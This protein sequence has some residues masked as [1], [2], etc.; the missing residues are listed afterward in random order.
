MTRRDTFAALAGLAAPS[1]RPNIL[2]IMADDLGYADLSCYGRRDYRTPQLDRLAA[3]GVRF[4]NAYASSCVCSPTRVALI[5]GRYPHRLP[6]G[7]PEPIP[8]YGFT[9]GLPK[10]H[11]T[12]PSLLR[13]AGYHTSLVGKWHL[14]VQPGFGPL[15][16]GYDDFFGYRTGGVDYFT[17]QAGGGARPAFPDLWEGNQLVARPGYLTDLLGD[18]AERILTSRAQDRRPFLLS[19]HFSAP[20]W[21]WQAPEDEARAGK[22]G[23]LADYGGGSAATYARIVQ[24]MDERIGRVLDHLAKLGLARNTLVVF[25][26]DNGGERFSDNWPFS[27][28]KTELLEGGLRVP[29]IVRWPGRVAAGTTTAQTAV[30][31]DW[32]PTLLAAAGAAPDPAYPPD[33]INLFGKPVA[34]TLFWRYRWQQQRA[35]REGDWKLLKIA[36][37]S[38][39]F[40]VGRDPQERANLRAAH[41]EVFA[42]LSQAWEHWNAGMLPEDSAVYSH[43]SYS[44]EEADRYGNRRAKP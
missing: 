13:Q 44:D 42:R 26:S 12:L 31:M 43:E 38:F 27:G 39:L 11:P 20:H 18:R 9:G 23:N 4:T 2:F 24:R 1:S 30:T 25:T 3:E 33:G 15:D 14:G 16:A 40:D 21:P 8:T 5:T 29:A 19:L 34:R 32:M 17:H 41:P 35:V 37:N 6:V 36:G 10:D 22:I 28:R 7:L